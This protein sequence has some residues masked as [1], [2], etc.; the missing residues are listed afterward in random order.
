MIYRYIS[1]ATGA[2]REKIT[3]ALNACRGCNE[4]AT[5][6]LNVSDATGASLEEI[7]DDL[8]ACLWCE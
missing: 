6:M 3:D 7:K 8:K 2:S 4:C 1:D 5:A